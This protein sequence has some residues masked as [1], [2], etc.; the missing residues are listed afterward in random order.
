MEW[1]VQETTSY[2]LVEQ[3]G[4][5]NKLIADFTVRES[6]NPIFGGDGIVHFCI[7]TAAGLI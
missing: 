5:L 2:I 6:V 3:I 1:G 4:N 7:S